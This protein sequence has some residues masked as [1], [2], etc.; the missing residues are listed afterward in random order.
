M[1]IKNIISFSILAL[2][3]SCASFAQHTLQKQEKFER[4]PFQKS[5]YKIK[6]PRKVDWRQDYDG[7]YNPKPHVVVIDEKIGKYEYR[8]TG[9][10]G[11]E[12]VVKFQRRDSVDAMAEADAVKSDDN[13]FIYTYTVTTS[14]NSPVNLDSFEIQAFAPDVKNIKEKSEPSM[15]LNPAGFIPFN[16]GFWWSFFPNAAVQPGKSVEF[17]LSSASPPGIVNC[18]ASGGDQSLIVESEF[19]MPSELEE[20]IPINEDLARCF[21]IGPDER[22]LKFNNDQKTKYLLDNLL[23]FVMAGWMSEETAKNYESILKEN[24]LNAVYDKAKTDFKD[25]SISSEVFS[26]INGFN[27]EFLE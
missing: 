13:R 18:L 6:Q 23:K 19:E 4:K 7:K 8:W 9:F 3:I 17:Y 1:K 14:K 24:D 20:E 10:D 25:E 21:T 27:G 5:P 15:V 11:K 22:L 16:E 2:Q 12:I 26:I